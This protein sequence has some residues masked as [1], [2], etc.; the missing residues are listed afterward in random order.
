MARRKR[1]GQPEGSGE[2]S[3]RGWAH[4]SWETGEFIAW[5]PIQGRTYEPCGAVDVQHSWHDPARRA[6]IRRRFRAVDP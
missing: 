4:K 6:E 2:E 3:G 1:E 5:C